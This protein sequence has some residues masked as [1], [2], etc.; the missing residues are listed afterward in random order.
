MA[1]NRNLELFSNDV[2]KFE[3]L[4]FSECQAHVQYLPVIFKFV[5]DF[6]ITLC[7]ILLKPRIFYGI[8][9]EELGSLNDIKNALSCNW[10]KVD[11][12][13]K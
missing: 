12:S 11:I 13:N 2:Q 7:K 4:F 9:E 8:F 5:N 1:K 3:I 6:R 10:S